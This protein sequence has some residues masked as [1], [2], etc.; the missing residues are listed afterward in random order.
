VPVILNVSLSISLPSSSS[1]TVK[2]SYTIKSDPVYND[3]GFW[4]ESVELYGA[5]ATGNYVAIP[6]SQIYGPQTYFQRQHVQFTRILEK[7]FPITL[8][9]QPNPSLRAL[10][11]ST[12]VATAKATPTEI[13]SISA[14]SN[15][16]PLAVPKPMATVKL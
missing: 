6:G 13:Q 16:V 7:T 14:P 9:L 2:V 4:R 10:Y 5:G 3:D 8:F 15:I 12:V 1:A 11:Y